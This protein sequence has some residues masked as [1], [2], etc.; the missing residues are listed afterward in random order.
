[1]KQHDRLRKALQDCIDG[2]CEKHGIEHGD[3]DNLD[4][5]EAAM[6]NTFGQVEEVGDTT[7]LDP[8]SFF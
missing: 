3:A 7:N 5:F 1:M 4:E 2:I 8:K 6:E